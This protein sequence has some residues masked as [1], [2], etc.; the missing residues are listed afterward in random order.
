MAR[1]ASIKSA[2]LVVLIIQNLRCGECW[3]SNRNLDG[4]DGCHS[5]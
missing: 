1:S 5:S 2:Q 3:T 4:T